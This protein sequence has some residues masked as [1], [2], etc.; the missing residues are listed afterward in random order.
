MSTAAVTMAAQGVGI[1]LADAI[2]ALP[3]L[4][5]VVLRRFEPTLVSEYRIIWPEGVQARRESWIT[6]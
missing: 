2:T 3:F 1:T 5:K 6:R 4:D